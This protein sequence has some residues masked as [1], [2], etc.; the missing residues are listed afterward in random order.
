MT[1]CPQRHLSRWRWRVYCWHDPH[2]TAPA[3]YP[4]TADLC[5]YPG[6]PTELSLYLDTPADMLATHVRGRLPISISVCRK[7]KMQP[8]D[9][10]PH[11]GRALLG[12]AVGSNCR[13]GYGLKFMQI[14][15]QTKCA[16]CGHDFIVSY[17]NWLHMALDH[18]V[19]KSVCVGFGFSAEWIEDCANKVLA[20]AACN[21]FY[22]RYRPSSDVVCPLSLSEFFDLRD[23]IFSERKAPILRKHEEEKQFFNRRL[24]GK[25]IP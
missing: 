8:F 4:D 15:R 1:G 3:A 21:G 17:Q 2:S 6:T 25:E 13:H 11:Q 14:T 20:C 19:P 22:N 9:S 18:V 5:P 10:Y 23:R 16:Y 24:W 12:K 7:D